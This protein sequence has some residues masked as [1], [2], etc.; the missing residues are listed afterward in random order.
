M[1]AHPQAQPIYIAPTGLA[2][3]RRNELLVWFVWPLLTLGVYHFVWYYKI[4]KEMKEFDPRRVVPTGGWAVLLFLCWTVIAPLVSYYNTGN[5]IN[6]AMRTARAGTCS[7]AAG[8]LLMFVFGLGV[9]YYQSK[10]N[11]I[12]DRYGVPEGTQILLAE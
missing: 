10:L 9:V 8:L 4:H 3:K 2:M 12:A 7:P 5:R 6:Q 1:A 11:R